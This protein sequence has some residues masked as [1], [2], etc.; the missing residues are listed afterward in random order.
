MSALVGNTE[1]WFSHNKAQMM[2]IDGLYRGKSIYPQFSGVLGGMVAND[3]C[4]MTVPKTLKFL[5]TILFFNLLKIS[6]KETRDI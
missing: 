3:W 5:Q 6:A 1:D 4:I 2:S